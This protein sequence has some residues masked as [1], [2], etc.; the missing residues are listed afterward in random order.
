MDVWAGIDF[1]K[2]NR[3]CLCLFVQELALRRMDRF[4]DLAHF[5]LAMQAKIKMRI[6]H[7]GSTA[8]EGFAIASN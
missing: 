2:T 6:Q 4:E 1:N 3:D 7:D 5:R 8:D